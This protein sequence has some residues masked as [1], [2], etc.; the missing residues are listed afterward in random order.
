MAEADATIYHFAAFRLDAAERILYDGASALTLPPKVFDTLLLFVRNPGRILSKERMLEEVWEGSFVEENN[1]AQNISQLRRILGETVDLK[2]IETVPKFGYRFV[3]N[4]DAVEATETTTE[5]FERTKA[6]IF[7]DDGSGDTRLKSTP[8]LELAR[9]QPETRYVLNGDV[10]IAYQVIGDGPVDIVFVM[11]WVSH[12]EYFWKHHLFAS[13]LERLA[14]FSRLILFDKRGTG[15]SDRVPLHG[16]PTLEQR[17]EDVHAVMDAVGSERAV[18]V[19]VSEGGPMCSLFAATYPE[20]TAAL[21]MIGTYAK[22]I[23]DK[24]YPW[25]PTEEQQEAF[26]ELMQHEWGGPVGIADRAPTMAGDPEFRDWWATYLRMGAS[27]GAAVALTKM[28]AEIDVRE[29]LPLIRVPTLVIHRSGDMCLRVEEGRYVASQIPNCEY[30][31]LGGIDHLPFVGEQDEITDEIERFV[32]GV[33]F[34][35]EYD[36]VLATVVSVAF[37]DPLADSARRGNREW[38]AFVAASRSFVHKQLILFKGREVSVGDEETLAAFDGPARAIRCAMA[39]NE[40]AIRQ[41]VMVK[42]GVH[43]GECDVV[44]DKY[45]GFAVDLARRVREVSNDCSVVVSRT[46]KDLVAGSGLEFTELGIRSFD[47]VDG[48]WRLFTVDR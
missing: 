32:T 25:A 22:R 46:V 34:A 14:S 11:G 48:E 13:F 44:N 27:P 10:N 33:R 3:A 9:Q 12:L 20:R 30:V 1:L 24:D 2:F 42:I 47:G 17:M 16:L 18:L 35:G 40:A 23:W 29:V 39:I 8:P 37:A 31:E 4:V 45:S 38:A 43:T 28:N 15:L 21:V 5:V 19:G 36:R 26:Y 7:I 6:H 41:N